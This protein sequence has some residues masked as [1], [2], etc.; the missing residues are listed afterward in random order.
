MTDRPHDQLRPVSVELG[1]TTA[2]PGSVLISMG[3]T[4]VLCTAS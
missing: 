4:R 2:T 1:F 3:K